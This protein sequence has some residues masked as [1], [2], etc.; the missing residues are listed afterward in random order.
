MKTRDESSRVTKVCFDELKAHWFWRPINNCPGRFVL[1][2]EDPCLPLVK[3]V[4]NIDEATDH[5]IDGNRDKV[6]VLPIEGGG[7]ISYIRSNGTVL[8]TLN[9]DAGFMR[10][11]A[12]LGIEGGKPPG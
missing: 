12:Q 9:T 10:K 11:L 3:L 6:V 5:E 7:L 1:V 8:H 4:P 2:N